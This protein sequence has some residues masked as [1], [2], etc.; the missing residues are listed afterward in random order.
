MS[1]SASGPSA[2]RSVSDPASLVSQAARAVEA[3]RGRA[4]PPQGAVERVLSFLGSFRLAVALLLLLLLLTALGTFAQAHMSLFDVQRK[5]FESLFFIEDFGPIS[6][7][8]PGAGLVLA[9]LAQNL[10]VGGLLRIRYKVATLGVIVGH[11]GILVLLISGLVEALT[12]EKGVLTL[13]EGRQSSVFRSY[14]EWEVSVLER[15]PD[16]TAA[17]WVVPASE[18]SGLDPDDVRR[19]KAPDLPFTLTLTGWQRNARPARAA[20]PAQGAGGWVAEA[21]APAK[22]AEQNTPCVEVAVEVGDGRPA[23]RTLLWGGQPFAWAGSLGG[24]RFEV[25]LRKRTLPLPFSIRLD[26]FVHEKHPG[27]GMAKRFSSYVTQTEG[28]AERKAHVTMNEPL[29]TRGYT[30]YQSGWG[31]EDAPE[32]APLFSSFSVVRNP[33]DRWP[34]AACVII[35][36]GMLLHYSIRL[37][38]FLT[39][40]SRRQAQ[41]GAA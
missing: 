33:S 37:A 28:R 26:D 12:S 8:L 41:K 7:P 19:V 29:R 40:E 18:L 38:R 11:V 9:V 14:Y 4:R 15:R 35:F 25:D 39:A 22:E 21:I 36:L 16:G 23:Q 1:V 34:I 24:R 27:T 13:Y 31:P 30:L 32:G 3:P 10:I 2:S 20:S 5:Y 17:E 6:I